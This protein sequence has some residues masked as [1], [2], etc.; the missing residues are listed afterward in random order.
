MHV[1]GEMRMHGVAAFGCGRGGLVHGTAGILCFKTRDA[2][3]IATGSSS[4][5]AF[6]TRINQS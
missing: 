6:A 1:K 3:L 4:F 5:M 2:R